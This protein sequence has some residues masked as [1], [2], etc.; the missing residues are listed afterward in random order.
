M[1]Y[2]E[3]IEGLLEETENNIE[4]ME[5]NV[6]KSANDLTDNTKEDSFTTKLA[7][8]N[9]TEIIELA[10][11]QLESLNSLK[12]LVALGED[13]SEALNILKSRLDACLEH[14]SDKEVKKEILNAMKK[15]LSN[16]ETLDT[17][18]SRNR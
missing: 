1:N 6:E 8:L 11:E 16:E 5:K 10:N 4:D 15:A 7:S 17:N 9:E 18:T 2:F 3:N 13:V 12:M 14:I